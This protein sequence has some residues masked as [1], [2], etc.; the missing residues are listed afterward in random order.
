MP[1]FPSDQPRWCVNASITFAAWVMV[2]ADTPE[3]ALAEAQ[4][5]S[6]DCFDYDTG[7]GD[8]EFNAT[9]AVEDA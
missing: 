4:T 1:K 6:A 2:E 9:P 8:V 7:T 3:E 5:F